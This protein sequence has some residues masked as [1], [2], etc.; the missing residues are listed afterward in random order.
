MAQASMFS[1]LQGQ[2]KE[3]SE[4]PMLC[5]NYWYSTGKTLYLV[6]DYIIVTVV[7]VSQQSPFF[8][9]FRCVGFLSYSMYSYERLLPKN[10]TAE[11]L[12][13][14]SLDI[15]HTEIE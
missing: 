6:C 1:S 10:F 15:A 14:C 9:F 7:I 5:Y 3:V 8:F 2:C 4:E 13:W 12:V 11:I